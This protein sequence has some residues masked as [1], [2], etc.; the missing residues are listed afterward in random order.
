MTPPVAHT[1]N[2]RLLRAL[3]LLGWAILAVIQA[4]FTELFH[5]EAY[6]W[7]YSRAL[8]WGYFHQPPMIAVMIRVGTAILPGEIGVR[9]LVILMSIGTLVLLERLCAAKNPRLFFAIAL[10]L[11]SVHLGSLFAAPDIPLLFFSALFLYFLRSYL[12]RDSWPQALI[13]GLV[14][15][16]ILYSKYHGIFLL[17]PQSL[18]QSELAT[19]ALCLGTDRSGILAVFAASLLELST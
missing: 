5:D 3:I 1:S 2:D 4:S 13:L 19:Q 16:C 11:A 10:S 8:D 12:E 17:A 7:N 6:Y 9:L 18:G 15:A 14:A